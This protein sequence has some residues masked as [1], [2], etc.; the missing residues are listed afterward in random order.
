M[1]KISIIIPVY[2]AEKTLD[3]CLESVFKQSLTS[4]EIIAVNDGSTDGSAA[5]LDRYQ[6][7]LTVINQKNQ[8]AAVARNAGAGITNGEF[9]IFVDADAVLE[10][11]MLEKML[12]AM[13]TDPSISFVYSS[14]KFGPKIFTLWPFDAQKLRQQPYIHTTTLIRK[15]HFPGFDKNLKRF[16]DWDLWLTMVDRGYRGWYIPQV[17]F[18][19]SAG[20]TMSAWLPKFAYRLGFLPAVR[21]YRQAEKIIKLK[22]HL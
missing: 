8:G 2:N 9:I 4:Y 12:A 19:V 16:Q 18:A 3:R 13:I 17:L 5:V 21:H 22:H 11:T 14:F 1:P 10:S 7:R 15:Q 6:G 20:G